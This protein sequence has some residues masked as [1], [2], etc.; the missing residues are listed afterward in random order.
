MLATARPSCYLCQ[1]NGIFN[2]S[3]FFKFSV[4]R[5][6]QLRQ[7]SLSASYPVWPRCRHVSSMQAVELG[8]EVL[9]VAPERVLVRRVSLDHRTHPRVLLRQPRRRLGRVDAFADYPRAPVDAMQPDLSAVS[10]NK[11]R[12]GRVSYI[13]IYLCYF[14]FR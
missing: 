13:R 8:D 4:G 3:F 10:D 1:K 2:V 11:Y 6:A 14:C 7:L 5:S 9:D 12:I